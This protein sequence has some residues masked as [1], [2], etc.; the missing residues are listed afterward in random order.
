MKKCA[1]KQTRAFS[2]EEVQMVKKTHKFSIIM[3]IKEMQ[4]G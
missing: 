4:S 3:A 1:D 2:K